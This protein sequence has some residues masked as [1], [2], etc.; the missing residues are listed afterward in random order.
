MSDDPFEEPV[1]IASFRSAREADLALRAVS[2]EAIEAGLLADTVLGNEWLSLVVSP[3]DADRALRIV[4]RLWPEQR[5]AL[6]EAAERCPGCGSPESSALPRVRILLIGAALLLPAGF[7]AGQ[8]QLFALTW[9]I[10]GLALLVVPNRH[11]RS[12]GERWRQLRRD[13]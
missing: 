4:Q 3:A 9:L 11:C 6:P 1:V 5:P 2:G 13:S 8:V 7:L 10:L 12:C